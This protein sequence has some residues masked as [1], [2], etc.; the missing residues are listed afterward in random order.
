MLNACPIGTRDAQHTSADTED[1]WHDR[2]ME[3]VST[4]C[5]VSGL[6]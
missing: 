6:E 1:G 5:F 3:L 2:I 4:Q